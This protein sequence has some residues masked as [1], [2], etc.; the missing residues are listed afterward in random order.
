MGPPKILLDLKA[1]RLLLQSLKSAE[2][3]LDDE[4]EFSVRERCDVARQL[5]VAETQD[6]VAKQRFAGVLASLHEQHQELHATPICSSAKGADLQ[7][8]NARL[9]CQV[10]RLQDV[11]Q[12]CAED[13]RRATQEA[14]LASVEEHQAFAARAKMEEALFTHDHDLQVADWAA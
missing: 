10:A 8:E 12:G 11:V 9:R 5:R 6:Q 2:A 7:R 1:T 4:R 14:K 3:A 13:V